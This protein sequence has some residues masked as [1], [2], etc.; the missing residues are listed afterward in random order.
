MKV[1]PYR[2]CD[3]CGEE[4]EKRSGCMNIKVKRLQYPDYSD[5]IHWFESMDICASCGGMLINLVRN[6][7]ALKEAIN[8]SGS[9]CSN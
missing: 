6:R 4:Y 8:G 9:I 3:I 5:G 1:K 2:I 7:R